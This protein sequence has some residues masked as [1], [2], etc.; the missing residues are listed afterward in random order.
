MT[1]CPSCSAKIDGDERVCSNCGAEMDVWSLVTEPGAPVDAQSGREQKT[2]SRSGA[3]AIGISSDVQD[4]DGDL[5]PGTIL[6]GRYR[7]IGLL[8]RGGMGSVYRA[9]D[10]TLGQPVALKFLPDELVADHSRLERFRAEVRVSRQVSHANVCRVHDIGEADGR[11]FLSME[12]VDGGD[13]SSLLKR[14]GRLPIDRGLV[15]ARQLCAGLAAAHDRGV[16]HRDLKP[17]N[18]MIDSEGRVRIADFGLAGIVG[19]I[20]GSDIRSGTPGYMAPETLSGQEVTVRSDIYSLGLVLYELF[21]GER[22]FSGNSMAELI[23][24]HQEDMPKFPSEIVSDL[25]PK[26]ERAILQ[27]LE[28]DPLARPNSAL[29]VSM[30][31]P[32]GDPLAAALAAGETPAPEMVAQAGGEGSLEPRTAWMFL[33]AIT[34]LLIA[35]VALN[36]GRHLLDNMPLNRSPEVQFDRSLET[37]ETL[38]VAV[39]Q[40]DRVYGILADNRIQREINREGVDPAEIAALKSGE[41]SAIDFWLRAAPSKLVAEIPSGRVSPSQPERSQASEVYATFNSLGNLEFLEVVP[42][43]QLPGKDKALLTDV[44][45]EIWD[46]AFAAAGLD[47]E[48]FEPSQPRW[49]PPRYVDELMAWSSQDSDAE[50]IVNR[51]EVGIRSGQV[52]YMRSGTPFDAQE[53]GS[54]NSTGSKVAQWINAMLIFA[55]LI[56]GALMVRRN[57]RQRRGDLRGSWRLAGVIFSLAMA[58]WIV[59]AD[60]AGDA[61]QE[62]GLFVLASG[63]A[64]FMAAVVWLLYLAL[65][66]EVR[67]HW[68]QRLISWQRLMS[69]SFR[70]PLAGR[71]VLVGVFLGSGLVT[72]I[73]LG[74][75]LV[76]PFR[77]DAFGLSS[78]GTD[79]VINTGVLVASVLNNIEQGIFAGIFITVLILLVRLLL[80]RT[81]AAVASATV[82]FVALN[83]LGS[84]SPLWSSVISTVV[85]GVVMLALLRYGLLTLIALVFSLNLL[86]NC[87]MTLSMSSWYAQATWLPLLVVMALAVASFAVSVGNQSLLVQD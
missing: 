42:E 32:G 8:G 33:G 83:A 2:P 7:L 14:V 16:L 11:V 1:N 25:D 86:G 39:P 47:P 30:M 65:E 41:I 36:S 18:V 15:T 57:M 23:R 38:G 17:A 87:P 51:I 84:P 79:L 6:A 35:S 50:L 76:R 27:C 46:K 34:L 13:M 12:L 73:A 82:L 52:V 62:L 4:R 70:D 66:P 85:L 5:S 9:D 29:A 64:L 24:K 20:D 78:A 68:P 48:S 72:L 26:I 37:L 31:L 69:G 28:K 43:E 71:H 63:Q 60:H 58:S 75:F 81:W 40:G 21:T 61:G 80:R 54:S 59:S 45:R 44:S 77:P 49:S 22:V 3:S 53:S 67:R 74:E 56:G 55:V 10:L 19:G